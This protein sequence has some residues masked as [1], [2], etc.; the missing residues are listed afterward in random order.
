MATQNNF[1]NSRSIS[2]WFN[3][4]H[5]ATLFVLKFGGEYHG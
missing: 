1:D 3:D 2:Y 5:D 4:P